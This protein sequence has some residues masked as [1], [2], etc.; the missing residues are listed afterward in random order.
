MAE[1]LRGQ[2]AARTKTVAAAPWAKRLPELAAR[3]LD[4]GLAGA[5]SA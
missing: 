2:F 3:S 1:H 5:V 4:S